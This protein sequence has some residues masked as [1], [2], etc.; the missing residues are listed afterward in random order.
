MQRLE[1]FTKC[2]ALD[3][4]SKRIR[5][6]SIHPGAIQ[7]PILNTVGWSNDQITKMLDDI[8]AKYPVGRAGEV[9]DISEAIAFLANDKSASFITGIALPVDGGYVVLGSLF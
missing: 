7:T 6:N 4:A 1:Q 8:A 5:I 3:L 2:T 9:S